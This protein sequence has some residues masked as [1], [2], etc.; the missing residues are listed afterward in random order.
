MKNF[1]VL[2]SG[3]NLAIGSLFKK[4]DMESIYQNF[5]HLG[6]NEGISVFISVASLVKG[7]MVKKSI[8]YQ[9][10]WKIVKN[11]QADYI[12]DKISYGGRRKQIVRKISQNIKV[13]NDPDLSLICD[14]KYITHKTF[15]HLSPQTFNVTRKNFGEVVKKIRSRKIVFKPWYGSGSKGIVIKEKSEARPSDIGRQ[16][17]AQEYTDTRGGIRGIACPNT[18]RFIILN[19]KIVFATLET[20]KTGER[21][22]GNVKA[23]TVNHKNIPFRAIKK[24]LNEVDYVFRNYYP[25]IYS[26]DISIT[27]KGDIFIGEINSKPGLFLSEGEKQAD[28]DKI[29]SKFFRS[30]QG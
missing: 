25:R 21:V 15:P 19:G 6:K 10:V 7:N 4:A 14:N 13:I 11:V 30:L 26:V 3:T 12:F 16:Y 28:Y 24:I 1:V 2:F 27:K 23:V 29:I 20:A 17:I 22:S 9:G 18:L 5:I 8:T